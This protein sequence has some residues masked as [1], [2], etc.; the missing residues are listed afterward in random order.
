[1][2]SRRLQHRLNAVINAADQLVS[3]CYCSKL[4]YTSYWCRPGN[5]S[6][7]WGVRTSS[8][9]DLDERQAEL[10]KFMD[11]ESEIDAIPT[12]HNIGPLS[13]NTSN[14]KLQLGTESRQWKIQYSNKVW[15]MGS[16]Y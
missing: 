12:I 13:L 6:E 9:C 7:L 14:L 3:P 11:I 16:L 15:R 5:R 8:N 1:M 4:I 10:A 2:D